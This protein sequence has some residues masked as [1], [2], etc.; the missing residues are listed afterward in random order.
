M[1]RMALGKEVPDDLFRLRLACP[2]VEDGFQEL[3]LS[4][5]GDLVF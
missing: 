1:Q 5:I 2:Q 3:Q 4:R